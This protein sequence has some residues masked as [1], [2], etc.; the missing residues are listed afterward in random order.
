MNTQQL[1]QQLNEKLQKEYDDFIERL[2]SLHQNKS[3]DVLMKLCLKKN[4]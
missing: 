1:K 3:L 4:L 2:K